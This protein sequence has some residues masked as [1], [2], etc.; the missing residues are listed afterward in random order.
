MHFNEMTNQ[1][2]IALMETQMY[3]KDEMVWVKNYTAA[4]AANDTAT[5]AEYESFGEDCHHI[6]TNTNDYEKGKSVFGFI[7][8]FLTN[9]AGW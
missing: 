9:T 8:K 5:I 2:K 7:N 3:T 6:I 4:F 1:E